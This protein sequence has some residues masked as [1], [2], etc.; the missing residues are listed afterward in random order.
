MTTPNIS[1]YG[2]QDVMRRRLS[3]IQGRLVQAQ[4]Q[5]S[6]GK[7]AEVYSG[8]GSQTVASVSLNNVKNETETYQQNVTK[9]GLRI[10][11]IQAGLNR[12]EDIASEMRA[13][14]I[15]SIG[16]GGLPTIAG[17][18]ALKAQATARIKEIIGILNSS[19]DGV[20]LFSG[21]ATSTVPM[22][23]PGA[24][25]LVGTPLDDVAAL[26]VPFP[27]TTAAS[28]TT[29]FNQIGTL[30]TGAAYYY[31]GD[32]T[33]TLMARIDDGVDLTY[34]VPANHTAIREILQGLY[35]MAT[36]DLTAVTQDGW[37]QAMQLATTSLA[38]GRRDISTVIAEHGTKQSTLKDLESRHEAFLATVQIQIGEVEDIDIADAATRLSQQQTA[39]EAT[40]KVIASMRELNLAR[41]L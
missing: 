40:Y 29:R 8:L 31:N 15:Q 38:D 35:A 19:I 16:E 13:A 17:S 20:Y 32:A 14:G 24:I 4:V 11:T 36:T 21:R 39:L 1:T 27:L 2:H 22:D 18:G 3:E 6:S 7:R 5:I 9:T 26:N 34:G 25:G 10:A 23:D 37:R 41:Y 12:I 33:G 28:G 30:L